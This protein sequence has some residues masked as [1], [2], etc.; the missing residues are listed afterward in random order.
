MENKISVHFD[1]KLGKNE[2]NL[3]QDTA[4]VVITKAKDPPTH[5]V[6]VFVRPAHTNTHRYTRTQTHR[7]CT[8]NWMEFAISESRNMRLVSQSFHFL[9][10]LFHVY[11]W[12][13]PFRGSLHRCIAAEQQHTDSTTVHR[14]E[15]LKWKIQTPAQRNATQ[16]NATWNRM[17]TLALVLL[18][19]CHML[20][21]L[22][23][24]RPPA[25]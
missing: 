25:L 9:R 1:S 16:C 13:H 20:N 4:A 3:W 18:T 23:A 11:Q 12:C 21:M 10:P 22:M 8:V 14:F 5:S 7:Q 2:A 15:A 17:E 19:R 6:F 24:P